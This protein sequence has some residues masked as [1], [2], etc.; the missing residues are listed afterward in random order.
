M[1]NTNTDPQIAE[2]RL[3]VER[4]HH[5]LHK[6][7]LHRLELFQKYACDPDEARWSPDLHQQCELVEALRRKLSNIIQN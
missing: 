5:M 2:A 1:N 6:D 7:A 4:L 3:I